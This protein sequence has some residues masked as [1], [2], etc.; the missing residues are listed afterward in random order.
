MSKCKKI[1]IALI[2]QSFLNSKKETIE[3]TLNLI[4]KA[5]SKNAETNPTSRTPPRQIFLYQ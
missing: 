5:T 1:K 4:K 3:K 2:Q